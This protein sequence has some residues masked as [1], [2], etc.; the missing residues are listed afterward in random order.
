MYYPDELVEEVRS[1][2]PI[3]DVIGNYVHLTKK[4]SNYFGLCPFH[5]EKT[6]SFSVSPGK[7]MYHCFGCGVGGNV[8]TFIMEYEN[9]SFQEALKMLADRAGIELPEDTGRQGSREERDARTMLLEMHKQA[10]LFYWHVLQSSTGQPGMAYL[11][12]R[13]V[14]D[15]MI[16][17]FGL[18]FASQ[19]S[20]ALY[21][22]LRNKGYSD[23]D[24]KDS[25]L[26]TISERGARDRF[27]NRVIFP[28]MDTNNRVIGFGGR[29]M[30]S[31][32]P[33]YLNSPET[34]IFDK[35]RNLY[36][37]N[38]A[39]RSREKYLLVCEGYMDVISMH[40]AGFTNAVASLGTAFTSQHGMIL[41]R[42]TEEVILC[43]DSDGA[44][45]KAALRAIP[46]LKDAGL[47]VRVLNL[48]P[49]KDP[50]EFVKNL[51]AD[52]FRE[53]IS[54]AE[55]A[56]LFEVR[57]LRGSFDFSDP[58][59]KSRFFNQA[60][61]RIAGFSNEIERNSYIEAVANRY[62]IDYSVL[63]NQVSRVGNREGLL[64]REEDA[65][66]PRTLAGR[67]RA[68]KDGIQD[69]ER[70]VLTGL[71]EH[72]DRFSSVSAFL[73]PGDYPDELYAEV[74][75]LLY[76]QL[77][78]GRVNPGAILDHF[79]SDEEKCRE[80]A[81]VFNAL[82]PEDTTE[83]EER[84]AFTEAVVRVKEAGLEKKSRDASDPGEL[85]KYLEEK[86]RLKQNGFRLA[87]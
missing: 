43:Y 51:G 75:A 22:Y 49:W 60:A 20:T 54:H 53:R 47:R 8:I 6:G 74:S 56:F 12:K 81:A 11:K 67:S 31:G 16:R 65:E 2:N 40:Q 35:S 86:Q 69:A 29:V 84:R 46:I 44:G 28:I 27:W 30:G 85:M 45:Q 71:S 34:R 18:G 83:E 87:D 39:K 57:V 59:E 33:K 23:A 62:G 78:E 82:L 24:M 66:R 21:Q 36:G 48:S 5:N 7:Q 42:Y 9:C 73:Q 55:N 70:L 68:K 79:I 58:E 52:E 72:P 41:K 3:V 17:A 63:K 14:S 1:R 4:G 61:E 15:D 26:V 76:G 77:Q 13:G 38:I 19:H 37:L 80:I 64:Q 10:A 50:D 25:G 32:D